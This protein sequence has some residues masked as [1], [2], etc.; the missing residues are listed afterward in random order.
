MYDAN[1]R[2]VMLDSG[3]SGYCSVEEDFERSIQT[4]WSIIT[5]YFLNSFATYVYL[6]KMFQCFNP[7]HRVYVRALILI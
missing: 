2:A 1:D 6:I 7:L 3:G 5:E 4:F